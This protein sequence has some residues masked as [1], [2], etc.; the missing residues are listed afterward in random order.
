MVTLLSSTAGD[1]E[2]LVESTFLSL[3]DRCFV[4]KS[5][6]FSSIDDG[7]LDLLRAGV[8][9]ATAV[10]D[11]LLWPPVS[12]TTRPTLDNG[13]RLDLGRALFTFGAAFISV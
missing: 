1:V 5:F 11:G 7:L 8:D 9:G 12:G 6:N 3:S 2:E 4:P 10:G 13:C